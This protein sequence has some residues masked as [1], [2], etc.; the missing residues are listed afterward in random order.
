MSLV[1]CDENSHPPRNRQHAD[2]HAREDTKHAHVPHDE[3]E[4]KSDE[5]A[6]GVR[7]ETVE[8]HSYVEYVATN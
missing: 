6:K 8:V 5:M 7:P 3:I 2:D 4:P 1:Q